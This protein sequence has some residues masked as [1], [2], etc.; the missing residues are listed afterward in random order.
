ML[1]DAQ[2]ASYHR[3]GYLAVPR[4][5]DAARVEALRRVTDAF[6]ERSRAVT[7]SDAIYDLDPRHSAAAPV[8][9]RIK[10][11]ADNDALYHWL[12][13]DPL[14]SF[15]AEPEGQPPRRAGRGAPGRGVLPALERRRA[16]GGTAARRRHGGERR[17]VGAAGQ[18]PRP[19]PHPLRHAGAVRRLHARRGHRPPGA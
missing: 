15:Q 17:H 13:L 12:G 1:T 16:G 6:V 9:R 7:T 4:L 2:I 8:L 19:D 10:N 18:P 11:P 14:P 5:I 3:D